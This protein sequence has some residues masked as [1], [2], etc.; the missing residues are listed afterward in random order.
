MEGKRNKHRLFMA[1]HSNK[2]AWKTPWIEDPGWL[3]SMGL[4]R[5]SHDW[6]DLAA[7]ITHKTH[8]CMH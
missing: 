6:G 4:H 7:F 1:P 8:M 3:P 5:V 2:L